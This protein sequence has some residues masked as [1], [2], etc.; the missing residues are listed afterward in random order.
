MNGNRIHVR[1]RL[2]DAAG[3]DQTEWILES[4]RA[5]RL[6]WALTEITLFEMAIML[7]LVDP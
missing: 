3:Q 6:S 5:F 2:A 4:P 7:A 1:S